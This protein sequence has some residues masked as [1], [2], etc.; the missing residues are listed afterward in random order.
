[1]HLPAGFTSLTPAEQL[2]V[3]TDMER[4]AR[5]LPPYAGLVDSLDQAARNAALADTDPILGSVVDE[6]GV[7]EYGSNWA[8]D[9][10]TIEANYDLM[11]NDGPGGVDLDCEARN[12]TGCWGHRDNILW[13]VG[14][15]QFPGCT[16]VMGAAQAPDG[17]MI[18]DTEV[19]AVVSGTPTYIYTWA[20]AQAARR[21]QRICPTATDQRTRPLASSAL[22]NERWRPPRRSE[23]P[24]A[25]SQRRPFR[26]GIGRCF[27]MSRRRDSCVTRGVVR[28]MAYYP[29]RCA[30][31]LR[32]A[33][34]PG[35]E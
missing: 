14:A 31:I 8:E 19:F 20:Q 9:V 5:G 13:K 6:L 17:L 33:G 7:V 12:M 32:W 1:M 10:N 15:A 22:G 21:R 23:P 25:F 24:T 27:A 11:Y 4:V 28:V 18:S 35:G 29:P 16:L 34:P 3:S 26:L 2:F 30:T